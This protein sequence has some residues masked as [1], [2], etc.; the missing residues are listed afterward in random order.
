MKFLKNLGLLAVSA[1]AMTACVDAD[2]DIHNFPDPDV[3]FTYNVADTTYVVDYYV[4]SKIQFNNTSAKTGNVQWNFGAEVDTIS[5]EDIDHPIVQYK[6]AG[7]YNVS[8]T[9]DG[10]GTKTYPILIY[11]I[12][13]VLS[14]AE[15]S[16]SIL[17]I[18][19]STVGF[20][21]ELPNPENLRVKYVWNF[22]EGT[23][24]ED[25][26]V[27]AEVVNNTWEG[28][29]QMI[30]GEYVIEYPGKVKFSNIGSQKVLI[31]TWF[32]IDEENRQ[33]E[34][35]YLNVQVGC[36]Y[37]CP[38]LYYAVKDGNIKALKLIDV[39][40]VPEGTKV[41][42][43]D[44]GVK[45]GNKPLN[46]C[47]GETSSVN[48][49][50]ETVSQGWIYILDAGKQYYYV[51]DEGDNLGDGK[52]TA[53]GV[54][55]SNVNTVISN[56]GQAAF[57]DPYRGFVYNGM[58]YYGDRG[59]G[60]SAIELTTRGATETQDESDASFR[61]SYFVENDLIPYYNRGI[62][63]GAISVDIYRDKSGVWWWGKNYSG[64]GIYRFTQNDIYAD[65]TAA[66]AA[67]MPYPIV[68]SGIKLSTFTLDEDKSALYVWRIEPSSSGFYHY[69]LPDAT[70]DGGKI[71]APVAKVALA[72]DPENTTA[73]EQIHTTQFALD[74]VTG[75]VYFAFRNNDGGENAGL[76]SGIVYYDPETQKCY[77]YGETSDLGFGIVI[78][79]TETKL[80]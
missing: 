61:G 47:Y 24:F 80:F 65:A 45:A 40:K 4:V 35:S 79:P 38:T 55:G 6:K 25:Q 41:F 49:N 50:E 56:E 48:E 31:Q 69:A 7:R 78:N 58:L 23:T 10:V 52:I 54:D 15:Q 11:D 43:F 62:G 3:D 39:T 5:M 57:M 66:A 32:N 2:P 21:L 42:P 60:V 76:H 73:D 33:L 8:L 20:A 18:N 72:A 71:A 1:F 28:L 59:N 16:D 19:K 36:N 37:E 26:A 51:N 9:I 74:K 63:Y 27:A 13:P 29:G 14:I 64:N 70:S 53:M 17:E 77:Q 44:M 68:L 67:A 75:R 34:D 30:D 46:L 22:P 12:A